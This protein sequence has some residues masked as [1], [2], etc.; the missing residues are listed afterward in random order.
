MINRE[1]LEQMIENGETIYNINEFDD[2]KIESLELNDKYK[3][4]FD[5]VHKEYTLNYRYNKNVY[6][7]YLLKDLYKTEEEAEWILDTHDTRIERFEPPTWEEFKSDKLDSYEF[8]TPKHRKFT[9]GKAHC[10]DFVNWFVYVKYDDEYEHLFYQPLT[11]E[12]Y[13]KA[14]MLARRLFKGENIDVE[15]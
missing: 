9:I 8:S 15:D 14:V 7:W 6:D 12:N 13:T 3:V 11:K 2:N 10:V 4:E 5:D 1:E